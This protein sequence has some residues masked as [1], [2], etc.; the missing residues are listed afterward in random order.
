MLEDA[1]TTADATE[2]AELEAFVM[3]ERFLS[4]QEDWPCPTRLQVRRRAYEGTE[5][6]EAGYVQRDKYG[7]PEPVVYVPESFLPCRRY[8]S[9]VQLAQA[10]WRA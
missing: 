10:G 7:R 4:G 8:A 9:V 6:E 1:L 2:L 3:T 5:F